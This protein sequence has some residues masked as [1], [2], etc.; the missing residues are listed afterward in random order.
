MNAY[1]QKRLFHGFACLHILHHAAEAPFYGSWMLEELGEHGYQISPGTL[2]P[3]LHALEKEGLLKRADKNVDGK[4]R[5]YYSI[6]PSGIEALRDARG[7][8]DELVREVGGKEY[9]ND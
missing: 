1:L 2:Y 8:L 4:I 3:L 5:K 6:T 7:Y 9:S